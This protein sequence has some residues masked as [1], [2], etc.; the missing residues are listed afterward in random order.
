MT[1]ILIFELLP[2]QI[3]EIFV[4]RG[5]DNILHDATI[6]E[7]AHHAFHKESTSVHRQ[8]LNAKSSERK[9]K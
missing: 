2:Q 3:S 4:I 8:N 1:F 7:F 6:M 9:G 5:V